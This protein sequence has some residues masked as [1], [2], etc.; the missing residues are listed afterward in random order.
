MISGQL[1]YCTSCQGDR[2]FFLSFA[3]AVTRTWRWSLLCC[4]PRILEI[5]QLDYLRQWLPF[6]FS[7]SILKEDGSHWHWQSRI[8]SSVVLNF[9]FHNISVNESMTCNLWTT[10]VVRSSELTKPPLTSPKQCR[11][12]LTRHLNRCCHTRLQT[13]AMRILWRR[14]ELGHNCFKRKLNILD[15]LA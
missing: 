4:F 5:L 1:T 2:P 6:S 11:K 9:S 3:K 8:F 7:M 10:D 14:C 13:L 15:C 12:F